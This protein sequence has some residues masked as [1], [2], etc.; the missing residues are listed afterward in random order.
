MISKCSHGHPCV[1]SKLFKH[2][3]LG[4]LTLEVFFATNGLHKSKYEKPF[5]LLLLFH[6]SRVANLMW[7]KSYTELK[8][9]APIEMSEI[10]EYK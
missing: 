5:L 8:V 10:E 7:K 6:L 4:G 9:L 1:N 3:T 2:K